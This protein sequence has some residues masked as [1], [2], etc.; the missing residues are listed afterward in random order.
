MDYIYNEFI[1]DEDAL[2]EYIKKVEKKEPLVKGFQHLLG[3]GVKQNIKKAISIFSKNNTGDG[4]YLLSVA[5][6][7]L[8]NYTKEMEYLDKAYKL[9]HP[10]ATCELAII[11]LNNGNPKK[12]LNFFK[13]A[14]KLNCG[15]AYYE[16]AYNAKTFKLSKK[17]VIKLLKTAIDLN[18]KLAYNLLGHYSTGKKKL[19]YY[20]LG[21]ESGDSEA[22][23]NASEYSDGDVRI[24]YLKK[25]IKLNE[26]IDAYTFL[27]KQ[28][29]EEK[30]L[31]ELNNLLKNVNKN[32][33]EILNLLGELYDLPQEFGINPDKKLAMSYYK[34]A[35][36]LG[37][38]GAT[39]SV[40]DL[41]QLG[42]GGIKVDYNMAIKYYNKAIDM[43]NPNT[44]FRLNAL[45][46]RLKNS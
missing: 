4:I 23:L 12:A 28:Y 11:E 2:F 45:L 5:Y 43:G 15:R 30:N 21:C 16:F 20:N 32:N 9:K 3:I 6:R 14:M 19:E 35:S 26:N 29:Q 27:I 40:G 46:D 25:A 13:E 8:K 36:N 38:A 44:Q 41:Y 37:H 33:P 24:E 42:E 7:F 39:Q 17:E 10:E 1:H 31:K 22:C 18:F 34:K